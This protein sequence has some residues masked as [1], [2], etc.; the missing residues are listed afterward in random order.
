MTSWDDQ[1]WVEIADKVKIDWSLVMGAPLSGK[2]TLCK[3]IGGKHIG[4]KVVDWK[5][6]EEKVKKSMGSEEEPFEGKVPVDKLE[7][8]VVDMIKCDKQA[9]HRH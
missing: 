1:K 4:F 9:G 6:L 3:L 5:A 7:N 8:A 2:T